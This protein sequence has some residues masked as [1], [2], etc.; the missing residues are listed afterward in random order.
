M[1]LINFSGIASGI[2]TEGL[3]SATSDAA[4]AT[5]VRPHQ[6]K[7]TQLE[8]TNTALDTLKSLLRTLQ[9]QLNALSTVGT[10]VLAKRATSSDE[11]TVTASA[12]GSA[13]NGAYSV[14]V[15][16][17]ARGHTLSLASS[18]TYTSGSAVISENAGDPFSDTLSIKVG[19][20]TP[21]D[22]IDIDITETTTLSDFVTAFNGQT[23]AA[24]ASLVNVGTSAAPDYRLLIKSTKMGDAEGRIYWDAGEFDA[25]GALTPPAFNVRTEE[26][27]QDS[28]FSMTGISGNITRPNN[29]VTDLIQ[30]LSFSLKG[31]G[32]PTTITV[33]D[34]VAATTSV[35]QDF[36]NSYNDVVAFVNENNQVVRQQQGEDVSNTFQPLSL[37]R[38][39]DNAITSIRSQISA[40]AFF[41]TGESS[42]ATNEI[43]IFADLGITTASDPYNSQ[44]RT[45]GG[46]LK[47][48]AT[49]FASAVAKEPNS[50]TSI[51]QSF[52]DLV[53]RQTGIIQQYIGF[54]NLVD[55]SLNS[56]KKQISD[57]ND[58]IAQAEASIAQQEALMR[59][60]F[61]RLEATIGR[62]QGQQS[63][64]TSALAGLGGSG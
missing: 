63:A 13:A 25:L 15:N 35:I 12:S 33:A 64:L 40:S 54:N 39:D 45:G 9:D 61:A 18:S 34:D 46:T 3:I 8:E 5:R 58:R 37:T 41:N 4:R 14:T 20:P 60:R 28:S 11:T 62:M 29:T 44:T 23:T 49:A 59:Q 7:I 43:R 36:I 10:G 51:V 27:A 21:I 48:N 1:P 57:L 32:G 38:V 17:L 2:D 26:A 52:A 55:S 31:E 6:T 22:T 53:G 56:N 42:T 19:F 47:F 50:V 24:T 16:Q 30:G